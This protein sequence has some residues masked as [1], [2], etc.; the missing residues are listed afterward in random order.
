VLPLLAA[1]AGPADTRGPF[2]APTAD[3][4]FF[5]PIA[6]FGH[7]LDWKPGGLDLSINRVVL[8]EFLVLV[9]A[10]LLFSVAFRRPNAVPRGAQNAVEA[11]IDFIKRDVIDATLGAKGKVYT[12]YL[13]AMFFFIW[14]GNLFE[15]VPGIN[16][17][18]NSRM[19][20]PAALAVVTLVLYV[21]EGVKHHGAGRYV[22][23]TLFPPGVPK[24]VYLIL[25]PIE[26][27][28]TWVIRPLTLCIRL[29]ANMIAGHLLLSIMYLATDYLL[30]GFHYGKG[31][32]AIFAAGSFL[33]AIVFTGFELFVG[34][35]QAYI[36]TLLTAVYL[37]ASMESQH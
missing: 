1:S 15:I 22:M 36:F 26:I 7:R 10:I 33:G 12:P 34:S 8:L 27:I 35:L 37:A 23:D 13:L 9:I 19:G 4:F 11:V 25:T 5:D 20:F 3:D 28:S 18:V 2:P 17:P 6:V 24:P 30:F 31:F 29:A 21:R 32:T 14:I 16:F